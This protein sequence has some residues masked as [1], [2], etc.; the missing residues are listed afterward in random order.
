MKNLLKRAAVFTTVL[1]LAGC[2][3]SGS[4]D[5]NTDPNTTTADKPFNVVL[6]T[7]PVGFSPLTTN[8]A[9]STY[10]N[11][12]IYET[13]Y[14]RSM[15][16]SSYEPLLA[17]SEPDCDE[18][19][20]TCTIELQS[21]VTFHDGTP[22]NA[23]AVKYT[24]ERIKDPNYGAARASIASSIEEVNVLDDTHVEL[25]TSYPDGVLIAKLAHAN[26]AI[27]SP[28]ADQAQDLMTQ[29]V[30]TG[31]YQFVSAISGSEVKLTR[32]DGYWG[33]KPEIKDVTM[34]VIAETSTAISRLE[35][36][37]ADFLPRVPVN[38][39]NRVKNIA[40]VESVA[41]SSSAITY[42]ALRNN[43][44]V[45]PK[46]ADL[47][48]RKA[49]VMAYDPDG[50]I[51][52][53]DG[54]ASYSRSIVGPTLFG[55]TSDAETYGYGYDLEA[56]K[57]LVEEG[58]Y[59]DEP[60]VFLINNRPETIALAEYIQ[61]NLK[62]AGLN[63]VTIES[64]EWAAYL[65]E[66]QQDNRYDITVLTWSNVTGDGTEMLDP[67]FH[68]V[69]SSKRV[70]YDNAEFDALVD[71][72][73]QT[74]DSAERTAAISAANKMILDDAV[75]ATLYNQYQAYAFN[76]AYTNVE[77]DAGGVFYVQNFNLK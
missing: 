7:A 29:P 46:M 59:A 77:M 44:S 23:E 8:D 51:A 42:L 24:I 34:T 13:L 40:N 67:N 26:S 32:Y 69:N 15:D 9:P 76:A 14:R 3:S 6:T 36:G 65:S 11:A 12:Q 30:G 28:T 31:P 4:N 5:G 66:T 55:Y 68:S 56:A 1:A 38:Q 52:S 62:A 2:S 43:S 72:S 37:E 47:N 74:L 41:E 20:T 16:G 73:K 33:E 63:N 10:V 45:N 19:G 49:I 27:I 61:S 50:Y 18:A 54:Y 48:L 64:L 75:A 60:I 53:V 22:F 70:R 71:A 35:T 57:K 21:G 39:M 58:G 25:K 17:K